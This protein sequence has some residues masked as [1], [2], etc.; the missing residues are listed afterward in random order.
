MSFDLEAARRAIDEAIS[1]LSIEMWRLDEGGELNAVEGPQA[2]ICIELD[3]VDAA[4]GPKGSSMFGKLSLQINQAV[5]ALYEAKAA[6]K[7]K[8]AGQ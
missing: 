8:E 7:A 1:A 4:I 3:R 6:L 2:S 5:V